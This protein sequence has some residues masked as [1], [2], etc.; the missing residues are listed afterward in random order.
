MDELIDAINSLAQ[1][2]LIGA[3]ELEADVGDPNPHIEALKTKLNKTC[4]TL[5]SAITH[6]QRET[7]PLRRL[8][9]ML[10]ARKST[11]PWI[12]W[13]ST[14]RTTRPLL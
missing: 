3:Q 5:S 11:T 10:M 14:L 9:R 4:D 12:A 13:H 6:L 8:V 7:S 1:D 2:L